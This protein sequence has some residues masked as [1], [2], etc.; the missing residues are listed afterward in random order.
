MSRNNY[1]CPAHANNPSKSLGIFDFLLPVDIKV[2]YRYYMGSE[3]IRY[4]VAVDGGGS[5][6]RACVADLGGR[7]LG[8]AVGQSANITTE[9]K[10]SRKNILS[11]ICQA[12]R[13][14]NLSADRS[15]SDYAY[16]GLAGAI[17]DVA[18]RL[19]GSLD[20]HRV[21]VV[22]D[23]VTTVQ[24]AL[25]GGDG[26]VALFGTG[27]F[28]TS[29]RHGVTRNIGGWGFRLGD[30]GS[31]A[32]LGINLLRRTVQAHD[33]LLEH[34]PLTREILD[35]FGGTP[36]GLV[37][38]VQSASPM[39]FGRFVPGLIEAFENDDAVAR[40]LISAAVAALH[41]T[42]GS[43]DARASGALYMLGGLGPFYQKQLDPD[44]RNLCKKPA[45]DALAGGIS[46]A[47][48]KLVGA[49]V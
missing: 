34:S 44:F 42:L 12:Y 47:Q 31:G 33:G 49:G 37:S 29:R 18:Q 14:A 13:A 22:T 35:R 23:R 5:T 10:N 32:W 7:I 21:K 20:F 24:G 28:F 2:F 6:C 16:L 26:T 25:G 41:K 43:L 38:F 4:I 30:D 39:E 9:F 8:R 3:I 40:T 19:E 17:G 15:A 45:G 48:I 36:S 1:F 27:S 46:L 11:T